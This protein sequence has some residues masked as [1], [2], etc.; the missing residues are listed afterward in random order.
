[1]CESGLPA[2]LRALLAT[3]ALLARRLA[4]GG[5]RHSIG[6]GVVAGIDM[7]QLL[8][9][10]DSTAAPIAR[11]L[12]FATCVA[13]RA[14]RSAD[15]DFERAFESDPGAPGAGRRRLAPALAPGAGR[16]ARLFP[17]HAPA[18]QLGSAIERHRHR[19][20]GDRTCPGLGTLH[21][22]ACSWRLEQRALDSVRP[23]N[24]HGPSQKTL[25]AGAAFERAL[26]IQTC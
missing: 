15:H 3:Q 25:W 17:R 23:P 10:I 9:I 12:L 8:S 7:A 1:M 24:Q 22:S 4:V 5:I 18:L 20:A 13:K 26:R 2:L 6:A 19:I 11:F 14:E 16:R 21:L